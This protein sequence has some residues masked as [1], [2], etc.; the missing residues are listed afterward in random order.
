MIDSG[1]GGFNQLFRIKH[2]FPNLNLIYFC[3]ND[4]CPYGNK[5]KRFLINRAIK[6]ISN[7]IEKYNIKLI[8]IACNT[9][10]SVALKIIQKIFKVKVVGTYPP[11][12]NIDSAVLLATKRTIKS[13]KSNKLYSNYKLVG[14]KS[15]ALIIEKNIN[16]VENIENYIKENLQIIRNYKN[17]ILACTHYTYIEELLQK[18]CNNNIKIYDSNIFSYEAYKGLLDNNGEAQLLL[19]LSKSDENYENGIKQLFKKNNLI[20]S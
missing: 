9:M 17:I 15:L 10:T 12:P 14:L 19:C 3:D 18:Y 20:I 4:A 6:I 2:D 8:I 5:S 16:K 7:L 11:T 13:I 1:I